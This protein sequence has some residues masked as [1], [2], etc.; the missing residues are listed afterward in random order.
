VAKKVC[1]KPIIAKE[2]KPQ[3]SLKLFDVDVKI[4]K[5]KVVRIEMS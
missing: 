1:K 5:D 4:A 2:P 3:T